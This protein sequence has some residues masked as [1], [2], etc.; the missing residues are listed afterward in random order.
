[1]PRNGLLELIS[2]P[3]MGRHTI[4]VIN[5]YHT[6]FYPANSAFGTGSAMT[7]E[8]IQGAVTEMIRSFIE[9][10]ESVDI[11]EY[12]TVSNGILNAM[13]K[14]EG[15]VADI[16]ALMGIEARCVCILLHIIS[17]ERQTDSKNMSKIDLLISIFYLG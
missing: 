6:L 11:I 17:S 10:V 13:R 12:S 14:S 9:K 7:S 8:T 2:P 15:K 16:F 3:L 5:I 1:M 4:P